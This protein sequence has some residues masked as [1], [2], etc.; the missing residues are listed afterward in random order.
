MLPQTN[1]LENY[2]RALHRK[3]D[4]VSSE[5]ADSGEV[6]VIICAAGG[7][8]LGNLPYGCDGE[9][10]YMKYAKTTREMLQQ[11]L[12]PVVAASSLAASKLGTNGLFVAVGATAA[13]SP[14]VCKIQSLYKY[15]NSAKCKLLIWKFVLG[16]DGRIWNGKICCA[17][18][19]A[20]HG[21]GKF[22]NATNFEEAKFFGY[23]TFSHRYAG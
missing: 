15:E 16:W 17:S 2:V 13:L 20:I 3:W 5:G 8:Q 6:D 14:T 18:N 21:K 19:S 10:D 7:F 9:E 4:D 1:I 22:C 23:F 11:N 12:Y